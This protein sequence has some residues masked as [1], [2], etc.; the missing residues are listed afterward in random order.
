MGAPPGGPDRPPADRAPSDAAAGQKA[1]S[2]KAEEA[3]DDGSGSR[4]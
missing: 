3:T 1:L 4:P 2:E